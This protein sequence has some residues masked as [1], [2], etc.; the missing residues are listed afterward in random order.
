[1]NKDPLI[2]IQHVL[3]NIKD[4][5]KFSKGLGKKD[6]KKNILRQKK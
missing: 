4:I 1:M 5:E 3:D 6:L 2:F